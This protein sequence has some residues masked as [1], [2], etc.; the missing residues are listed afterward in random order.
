MDRVLTSPH[1]DGLCGVRLCDDVRLLDFCEGV[2]CWEPN[3]VVLSI[4]GRGDHPVKHGH[5]G[6]DPAVDV[7]SWR[8]RVVD[9]TLL[10]AE[11]RLNVSQF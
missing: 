4:L 7:D 11:R 6:D 8:A 9:V 3:I 2:L 10:E 5:D 1:L